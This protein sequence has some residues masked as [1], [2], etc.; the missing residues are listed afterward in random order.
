ML[1]LTCVTVDLKRKVVDIERMPMERIRLVCSGKELAGDHLTLAQ[2][3][4]RRTFP[5]L[6]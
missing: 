5:S 6:P 1:R 4:T 2:L 3:S